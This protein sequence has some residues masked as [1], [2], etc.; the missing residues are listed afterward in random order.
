MSYGMKALVWNLSLSASCKPAGER[1]SVN[2]C[3]NPTFPATDNPAAP[4]CLFWIVVSV[5][6]F[7]EYVPWGLTI[8]GMSSLRSAVVEHDGEYVEP[9]VKVCENR[10]A[11]FLRS[12]LVRISARRLWWYGTNQ[13]SNSLCWITR[14]S[15]ACNSSG[16]SRFR[17]SKWWTWR[18]R[19]AYLPG[20]SP[21]KA[22]FSRPNIRSQ[23]NFPAE[24]HSWRDQ[25]P[26]LRR[27]MLWIAAAINS[28]V[29]VSQ[30]W[31]RLFIGATCCAR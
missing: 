16:N 30:E 8:S 7:S 20:I 14:S 12:R 28:P 25:W 4:L 24:Q 23:L 29:P 31:V 13:G 6:Q 10:F 11:T 22:P 15:F 26:L 17:L 18:F 19:T 9:I 2:E 1:Y 27:L 21:V 3:F 5:C